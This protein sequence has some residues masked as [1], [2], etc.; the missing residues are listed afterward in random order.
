L[1]EQRGVLLNQGSGSAFAAYQTDRTYDVY[2]RLDKE[3]TPFGTTDY[4]YHPDGTLTQVTDAKLQVTSFQ[5]DD[6]K[7][8]VRQ[9]Q[10][11]SIVTQY[12][13]DVLDHLTQVTDPNQGVTRYVVDDL[14][15]QLQ[16][17][18]P[19][20][21]VASSSFDAAGN[22]VQATDA[23][24]QAT[25][26]S[27]DALNRLQ[28]INRPGAADDET[29][30]YDT[31]PNGVTKL[32]RVSSGSGEYVAYEYDGLGRVAKVTTPNGAI[33]YSYDGQDHAVSLTYPSGRNVPSTHDG[34]GN[35][36][37]VAVTDGT[38][39]YA[40]ASNVQYL[41]F[42]PATYWTYGNAQSE[43]RSFN[44]A[45]LPTAYTTGTSVFTLTYPV[46]DVNGNLAERHIGTQVETYSYD[47]LSRLTGA[48][49]GGTTYSFG[50]DTVG[51]RTS[52]TTNNIPTTTSYQ[53]N[54]NRL[55]S[56]SNWTY[57]LDANG[58]LTQQASTAGMGLHFDYSTRNQ[59]LAVNAIG[60]PAA[61]TAAYQYNALGQRTV[62]SLPGDT[63]KFVYGGGG[64]LLSESLADGTVVEEYV[65]LNGEPLAL[66]GR[67]SLAG[68]PNI[69]VLVDDPAGSFVGDW[70][71]TS[72]ASANNGSFR[73]LAAADP[74][75]DYFLWNWRPTVSGQY[76][77]WVWW[78][79]Q[80]TDG[81]QTTYYIDDGYSQ[82]TI[83]HAAQTPG[84]WGYLGRYHL[85]AGR[86][87]LMLD[88]AVASPASGNL[89]AGT[90]AAD[91]SRFKLISADSQPQGR[92]NYVIAD[93]IGTPQAVTDWSGRIVWRAVYAPFGAALV[94]RDPDHDAQP[95]TMN[96]RFAGQYF[97]LET[98]MHYNYFRD[99]DASTGRYLESDPIGL[100]GGVNTYGYVRGNPLGWID[101]F[102]LRPGDCY[103]TL[104][105][106]AANALAD[107]NQR[108]IKE[109]IEYAGRINQNPNG[110]FSYTEPIPGTRHW[111][112]GGPPDVAVMAGA[113]HTHGDYQSGYS[114]ENF[115]R[116]DEDKARG[117]NDLARSR[118]RNFAHYKE[119]LGTP[120]D[121]YRAFDP[122]ALPGQ[123]SVYDIPKASPNN[124]DACS[125]H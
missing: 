86:Q 12:A 82:G 68:A 61:S 88:E 97:D 122:N 98:G 85:T 125:C 113:Y 59:L 24:A 14:G 73:R 58:S 101:R 53:S 89:T 54:S 27:Y 42:G 114:N 65:Y 25:T 26:R 92:Y 111:S 99:Y 15:N 19:D 64:Q 100:A 119:F 22:L 37:H 71:V 7:R 67:S 36:T 104:E 69:D 8:L 62:K 32:C 66:L 2:N 29:Y 46:Y 112:D 81:T 72:Q 45:Y 44:Q 11:G 74:Y 108:S 120:N 94:D 103:P 77:M 30:T 23:K 49:V 96:L 51:N 76:D 84:T 87:A 33:A 21:G 102:G 80:P 57:T 83:Q 95:F 79:R 28:A 55:S 47:A 4:D 118:F 60:S 18:S 1:R 9:T 52:S 20:S 3:T 110:T 105:D 117:Y 48:A 40:L 63:R 115:S 13:Y 70:T 90:L 50:Y 93:Q 31:C 78:D 107:I 39:Q 16:V 116:P 34:G 75:T 41:P 5:Y 35:V 6:F 38:T 91:A 124:A 56:D 10:P 106:A 109:D 17:Q 121:N 123:P 43:V